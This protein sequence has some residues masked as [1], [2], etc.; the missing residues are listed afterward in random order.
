VC[1]ENEHGVGHAADCFVDAIDRPST[2]HLPAQSQPSASLRIS[3]SKEN[4]A[5]SL[6]D[7]FDLIGIYSES[8]YPQNTVRFERSRLGFA[9]CFMVAR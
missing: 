6:K 5:P 8:L 3:L 2:W 4:M 9:I 1:N 7:H